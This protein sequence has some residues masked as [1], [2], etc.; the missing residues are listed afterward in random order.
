LAIGEE[1]PK[2][3]FVNLYLY[4]STLFKKST[5]MVAA[6]ALV[7]S[8]VAPMAQA[9]DTTDVMA[10][11]EL[12]KMGIIQDNSSNTSAYN[13]GSSITRRE[14]LKIMMNLS[15]VKV[16]ETCVGKFAD[17][18]STDW[19]CKYAESALNA[20]FI[21]PNK[22]FRPN[23]RVTE[24]EALKMIMQAKGIAKKADVSDWAQA[25][26]QAA[27]EAGILAAGTVVST[28]AAKRSM[29][30]TTAYE[31]AMNTSSDDTTSEWEDD[32]GDL[33]GDLLGD[34]ED[35]IIV[36][37]MTSTGM[38]ST[39]M[40]SS[41]STSSGNLEVSLSP[42]TPAA[43]S[44]PAV[45]SA[46]PY[47]AVDF[48]AGSKD[49]TISNIVLKREGFGTRDDL[50]RVWFELDGIRVS[51]RASFLSDDTAT[52]TFSPALVIKAGST[53]TLKVIAEQKSYTN[54]INKVSIVSA[55]S[56]TSGGNVSGAFPITGNSMTSAT[57]AVATM[58]IA[59]QGAASEYKVGDKNMEF[60]R[61]L[62]LN[63]SSDKDV[64]VQSLKFRNSEDG[65]MSEDLENL[66]LYEGGVKVSS[67]VI[68]AGR[69]V[70]FK[71]TN[72][73]IRAWVS[74][75]FV[76][77]ADAKSARN[78]TG[79]KFKFELRYQE[80]LNAVELATGFGA[81]NDVTTEATIRP[82]YTVK[83]STVTVSKSSTSP[84]TQTVSAGTNDVVLLV[85]DATIN[86][87]FRADGLNL[88]FDLTGI[89]GMAADSFGNIRVYVWDRVY[90]SFDFK[91][92]GTENL[93]AVGNNTYTKAFD[94]SWTFDA[95][96]TT[97]KVVANIKSAATVGASIKAKL[98]NDAGE[99]FK[100]PRYLQNDNTVAAADLSV[101]A[102]GL[103]ATIGNDK[104]NVV[105]N[106]GFSSAN[107]NIVAWVQGATVY[108]A[109]V[110]AG[111]VSNV[112]VNKL[113]FAVQTTGLSNTNLLT[114]W[115]VKV[116]GAQVGSPRSITSGK[117]DFTDAV[118][119]IAKN[120][121][122]QIEVT[123]D[124]AT[125]Y[126]GNIATYFD[127]T[128]ST[129]LNATSGQTIIPGNITSNPLNIPAVAVAADGVL[130][131]TSGLLTVARDGNTPNSAVV[132]AGT[133]GVEL[134]RFKMSTKYDEMYV[135]DLYVKNVKGA[136]A[137]SNIATLKLYDSA[138]PSVALATASMEAGV[139]HFSLGDTTLKL[140]KDDSKVL[141]VK[142]DFN[143]IS[144]ASETGKLIKLAID[145]AKDDG[146]PGVAA[147]TVNWVNVSSVATGNPLTLI[148]DQDDATNGI[149]A[150]TTVNEMQIRK[151][152]LTVTSVNLSNSTFAAASDK[153]IYRFKVAA[154][155]AGD[156][157]L[158]KLTLKATLSNAVAF[159]FKLYKVS[160]QSNAL[161]TRLNHIGGIVAF[162]L[163]NEQTIAKGSEVEFVVK[164]TIARWNIASTKSSVS[165]NLVE[166]T[167]AFAVA[168]RNTADVFD[169]DAAANAANAANAAAA[170]NAARNTADVT[171][172]AIS[173]ATTAA[174]I[175]GAT[176]ATVA[177]AITA[178]NGGA[179]DNA[180]FIFS[181]NSTSSATRDGFSVDYF[182][183]FKTNSFPTDSKSLTE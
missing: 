153:E 139:A 166:T 77:Q 67:G 171:P 64:K 160:D 73:V 98:G 115:K 72:Y 44:I 63:K 173:A 60:A 169:A 93:N 21:A 87:A 47:M 3:L 35:V 15:S 24:A 88:R 96:K 130:V 32:L 180:D 69:D 131:K 19:G 178:M 149:T 6:L 8:T 179:V 70:T 75:T 82:T 151:T 146:V 86:Q 4:M 89:A 66:A 13:L 175:D 110:S 9:M 12:A 39:G 154:D 104:V 56:V 113:S 183:G 128:S 50:Y 177:A 80:D 107:T 99:L 37:D 152:A 125:A 40:T 42:S 102:D 134:A 117:V 30:I 135:K 97:I 138:N 120:Q 29:V 84:S 126:A 61:L 52:V 49:T 142:A 168:A 136:V 46:V 31:A 55:T 155:A 16:G 38:T 112:K 10:A 28:K 43:T 157:Y 140:P 22:Y 165:T 133:Q 108:K 11:N 85:A 164:A 48:T 116:N 74:K 54:V 71:L 76:I 121:T 94:S 163:H 101:S 145:E 53:Q 159:N 23:D 18:K 158:K 59:Y 147:G 41:G 83:G 144:N 167:A 78:T 143:T 25:Y 36:E 118:F 90:N 111:N 68:I 51:E 26:T 57:Y 162:K 127:R 105:R 148:N 103:A 7:S 114:N 95:G 79:D 45:A 34:D 172:A 27:I 65:E 2:F 58:D 119:T 100:T 174:A 124:V 33:L 91:T 170:L 161:D 81:P 150:A 141:I 106:D 20:W 182:S 1:S 122:A 62:V 17:M 137:D 109:T 129:L 132:V 123:C 14:M 181:D 156:A 92:N 5:A 176:P